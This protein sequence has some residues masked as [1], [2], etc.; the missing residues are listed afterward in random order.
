[1]SLHGLYLNPTGVYK[2]NILPA[3]SAVL[4]VIEFFMYSVTHFRSRKISAAITGRERLK[5]LWR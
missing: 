2:G 3:F 4:D 5:E 1:L